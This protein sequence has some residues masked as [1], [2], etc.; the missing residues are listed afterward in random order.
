LV[1]FG[2]PAAGQFVGGDGQRLFEDVVA[3]HD[4]AAAGWPECVRWSS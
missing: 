3:C 1:A 4:G 2:M